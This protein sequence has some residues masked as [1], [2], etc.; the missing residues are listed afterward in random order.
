MKALV[1]EAEEKTLRS[2]EEV[3]VFRLFF[4]GLCL[5]SFLNKSCLFFFFFPVFPFLPVFSLSFSFF[6]FPVSPV[7]LVFFLLENDELRGRGLF[8]LFPFSFSC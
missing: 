6:S 4:P 2:E 8:F 7:S 1:R 5:L 3:F